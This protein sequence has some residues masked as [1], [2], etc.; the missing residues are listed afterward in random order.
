[1]SAPWWGREADASQLAR[2]LRNA[3]GQTVP[4]LIE[5]RRALVEQELRQRIGAFTPQWTRLQADDPGLALVRLFSEQAEPILQRLNRLPD[6][7]FVEYLRSAGVTP[8][9]QRPAQALLQFEVSSAAPNS[10]LVARGF[11]AGARPAA[12]NGDLVIFETE[13]D[14]YAA[15][16]SIEQAYTQESGALREVDVSADAAQGFLPFGRKPRA[17]RAL[18]IG[19]GGGVAPS[20]S[21]SLGVRV[22]VPA[23][24]PPPVGLGGVAPLPVPPPPLLRWEL[25][26]NG[27]FEAAEVLRDESDSLLRSGCVELRIPRDW[28]AAVLSGGDQQVLRWLRLRIV[29]GSYSEAPRL[30]S[31]ALNMVPARAVRTLRNEVLEHVAGSQG[32]RLRLSQTPVVPG[33]LILEVGGGADNDSGANRW[34]EVNNLSAYGPDDKVYV[35][36]PLTGEVNFGDS[37]HGAALP[38]GFR[39]VRALSYQVASGAAGAVEA[40]E[41]KAL[42]HA[43]PFV[44]KVSNP[45][46]A[47]GGAD[48]EPLARTLRRG[49]AFVRARGRAVTVADYAVM[50]L[51]APGADIE[52]SHAVDGFHPGYPGARIAGVVGVFVVPPDTGEEGP[53]VPSEDSLSAVARYLSEQ[54]AATGVE[55]VAAPPRYHRVGVAATIETDPAADTGAVVRATL[56]ELNLYLHPLTGGDDGAG[57]PFGQT[58]RNAALVRRLLSRVDGL[59]AVSRLN[60]VVDGVR[61]P[62]CSDYPLSANGLIWP[63][64]HEILPVPAAESSS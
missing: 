38:P 9:A 47:A 35:L 50:A 43:A 49:P 40:G 39:N 55:V 53:L 20:P 16:A 10:V 60:L 57:W 46:P 45:Y 37:R 1:M 58:I 22:S 62:A 4:E 29:H 42:I 52:R 44:T 2:L 51:Q 34:R 12:G 30:A 63:E 8:L 25:L 17:G 14:L 7:V 59:R 64:G 26:R 11:Q 23:G 13:R 41:I 27:R 21:L 32:R 3:T 6:K 18:Y 56:S 48:T 61:R 5:A 15:N 54:V 28:Q 36:D 24:S 31:V 19:L 33:T